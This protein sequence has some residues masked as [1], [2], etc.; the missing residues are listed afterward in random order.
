VKGFIDIVGI[1]SIPAARDSG[2]QKAARRLL[3]ARWREIRGLSKAPKID[4]QGENPKP[5]FRAFPSSVRGW[6]RGWVLGGSRR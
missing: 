3:G 5:L 1:Q 2:G 4:L 6:V